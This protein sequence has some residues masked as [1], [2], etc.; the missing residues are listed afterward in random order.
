MS[1]TPGNDVSSR[2]GLFHFGLL[3]IFEHIVVI[4]PNEQV[5]KLVEHLTTLKA[6]PTRHIDPNTTLIQAIYGISGLF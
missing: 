2:C 5:R 6:E 4:S 3:S 1:H